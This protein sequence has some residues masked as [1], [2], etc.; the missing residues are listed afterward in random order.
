MRLPNL[1]DAAVTQVNPRDADFVYNES[2]GHLKH[3]VGVY[4]FE[5]S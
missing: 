4:F 2:A 5:T 1:L 3:L